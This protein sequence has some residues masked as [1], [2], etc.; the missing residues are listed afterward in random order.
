MD[1]VDTS[2]ITSAE[3]S[4]SAAAQAVCM[5][6]SCAQPGDTRIL[7]LEILWTSFPNWKKKKTRDHDDAPSSQRQQSKQDRRGRPGKIPGRGVSFTSSRA[8]GF[9]S[10]PRT[11][12]LDAETQLRQRFSHAAGEHIE[13]SQGQLRCRVQSARMAIANDLFHFSGP[14]FAVRAGNQHGKVATKFQHHHV[15]NGT[16]STPPP[17]T[18]STPFCTCMTH[19]WQS[20]TR[21]RTSKPLD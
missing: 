18:Q 4:G 3:A 20:T 14:P 7:D 12:A 2:T 5:L 1:V 6:R 11:K 17:T 9:S 10:S 13:R 8:A 21:T 15:I 19:A 16:T